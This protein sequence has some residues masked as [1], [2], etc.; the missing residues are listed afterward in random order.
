[1]SD[2]QVEIEQ[3]GRGGTIS[4]REGRGKR[5][6]FDWEFST[7]GVD[8]FIP[9]VEQWEALSDQPRKSWLKGRRQEILERVVE[10]IIRQKAPVAS[11]KIEDSW[12][13]LRF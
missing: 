9:T 1:M 5:L 6:V 11:A 4:Y 10:E 7:A 3:A 13:E 12:I 8:I 2:F